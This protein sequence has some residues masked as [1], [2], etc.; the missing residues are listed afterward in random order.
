MNAALAYM[1]V[2]L[3]HPPTA[4]L[5]NIVMSDGVHILSIKWQF[6]KLYF[7]IQDIQDEFQLQ[8]F[9]FLNNFIFWCLQYVYLLFIFNIYNAVTKFARS[10]FG[11]Q[12]K[13]SA[14]A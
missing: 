14:N 7:P 10:L 9:K 5:E 4:G 6:I 11:F 13:F 12:I 8:K 1:S 3:H 2:L